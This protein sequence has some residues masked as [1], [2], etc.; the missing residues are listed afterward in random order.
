MDTSTK[1]VVLKSIDYGEN[2]KIILLY[3]LEYG[4]ISVRAKGIKKAK[5]KLKFAQEPFCFGVY[6]LA[7]KDSHYVLKTCDQLESFYPLREDIVRFYAGCVVLECLAQLENE[8]QPNARLFVDTLK[9][10]EFLTECEDVY[11]AVLHFLLNYLK[12]AGYQ[13]DFSCCSSCGQSG[14]LFLDVEKGGV[15]CGDCKGDGAVAMSAG[16]VN[17]MKLTEDMAIEKLGNVK[18]AQSVSKDALHVLSSYIS[19]SMLPLKSV[20]ELIRL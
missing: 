18:V 20:N 9:T 11:I 19:R 1:A 13:L 4:K 10:L 17:L 3:S 15:V 12:Q 6:H 5:A 7:G 14:K 16:V 2:D 8:G